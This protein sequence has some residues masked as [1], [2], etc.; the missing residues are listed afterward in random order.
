M[1]VYIYVMLSGSRNKYMLLEN[2]RYISHRLLPQRALSILRVNTEQ[3]N[4]L[5]A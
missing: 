5:G 3:T 2:T 4:D 1:Y